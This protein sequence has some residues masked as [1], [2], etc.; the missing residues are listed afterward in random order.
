MSVSKYEVLSLLPEYRDQ[1]QLVVKDQDVDDIIQEI[2]RCQKTFAPYYDRI[3]KLFL[4]DSVA[5]IADEL[6][7]FCVQN[8][9]YRE[10]TVKMQSS[11]IPTGVLIRGM[12]DCKHYALFCGGVLASLNRL[13]GLGIN[14][15]YY[16]AGYKKGDQEPY[17]V[18]I[19]LYDPQAREEIWI[20]PTP[21]SATKVP[22]LLIKEKVR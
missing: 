15:W 13:Y 14:W 21:G 2:K 4:R 7:D 1:W 12:G 18:F 16:F 8:I 22:T 17:H 3:S 19:G 5:G 10:E 9:T 6:Y 11:A 20:D